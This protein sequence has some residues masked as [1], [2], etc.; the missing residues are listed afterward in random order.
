MT[1]QAKIIVLAGQSNAVGVGHV[2]YLPKSF[3]QETIKRF[4]DG[5]DKVSINY[6]SHDK[7][8]NGF[9]KTTVGCTEIRKDTLG[10]EVGIAQYFSELY[11]TEELFIVKC[12]FGGASLFGDWL[13]PSCAGNYDKD[14]Y[15]NQV[16]DIVKALENGDPLRAGWCYNELVKILNESIS[17]LKEKG[18]EPSICAFCWMQGETDAFSSERAEG[19]GKRYG[20][21]LSDFRAAFG[22]YIASDCVYIDALISKNWNQHVEINATK[23]AYANAHEN[24]AII[25]TIEEGL[26]T[27]YE[28]E[29]EPDVAHY[30]VE[31]T[32]RLGRLFAKRAFERQ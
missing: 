32:V 21:L 15:A 1:T 10:P 19:Y 5:Y 31:S 28:P 27:L 13:P 6:H 14:A 2:K 17:I 12:A 23:V 7:R 9:V 20:C 18:Y 29:D 25:D 11:P 8:S 3:D 4:Y 26:T 22:E 30:D 24:C 16:D